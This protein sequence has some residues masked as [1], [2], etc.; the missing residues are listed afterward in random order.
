MR[1]TLGAGAIVAGTLLDPDGAPIEGGLIEMHAGETFRAVATSQPDG[2]FSRVVPA[3]SSV[4]LSFDGSTTKG[5]RLL[6][7]DPMTVTA[8]SGALVLHARTVKR[9]RTLTVKAVDPDG[10]P[11]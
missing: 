3:G 8:D 2:T 6:A 10:N 11:I 1:V 5:Y 7:T 9:D 4:K